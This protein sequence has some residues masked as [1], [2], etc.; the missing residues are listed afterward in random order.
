MKKDRLT[1]IQEM[2][3]EDPD[4]S[5]LFFAL[6]KEQE[7]IGQIGQAIGTFLELKEK[8]LSLIHI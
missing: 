4:N 5:F 6:A 7:K 2:L 8:D 1:L 3:K